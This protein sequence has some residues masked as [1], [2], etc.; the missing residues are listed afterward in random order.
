MSNFNPKISIIIPVYNG[1]NYMK[2][3]IDSALNQTY[4][5]VEVIVINDGSI[6]N[7][8]EIALSYGKKIKYFS[9]P[10]GGVSTALNL[11]IEKMTGEYFSWLSHDDVYLPNK[12][13]KQVSFLSEMENKNVILF[14]DYEF[15]DINSNKYGQ[16]KIHDHELLIEKPLLSILRGDING[17][18]LLIPK[19]AFEECGIFDINLKCTQDYDLWYRMIKKHSFIHMDQILAKSRIHPK[20]TTYTNTNQ[21]KE[22]SELYINFFNDID[23]KTKEGLDGSEY[24]FYKNMLPILE[25]Y[26]YDDAI[27]YCVDKCN[28]IKQNILKTLNDYLVTIVFLVEKYDKKIDEK[29]AT[30]LNQTHKN[31]EIILLV[32]DINYN[33]VDIEK[34]K[35]VRVIEKKNNDPIKTGFEHAKGKY[36]LFVDNYTSFSNN[37]IEHQLLYSLL[38]NAN[39]TYVSFF[40]HKNKKRNLGVL[41]EDINNIYNYYPIPLSVFMF[42]KNINIEDSHDPLY[43]YSLFLKKDCHNINEYYINYRKKLLI[44]ENELMKLREY[45]SKHVSSNKQ[46]NNNIS[47]SKNIK[48]IFNLIKKRGLINIFSLYLKKKKYIKIN[49]SI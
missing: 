3:A 41:K 32:N 34:N 25:R 33:N 10:N 1:S 39:I 26:F 2:E 16:P 20:Q 15:I 12:I 6:D 18:T 27:N 44:N 40:D 45:I 8:E 48:E 42:S 49:K 21:M 24:L 22:G 31:M 9:K 46:K 37:R 4:K 11:G 7:T 30:M 23:I 13:E 14:S 47:A 17:I 35:N 29:I 5:N 36:V 28:K 19:K 43:K 38:Y